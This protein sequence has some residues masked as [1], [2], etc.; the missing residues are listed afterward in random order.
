M[1]KILKMKSTPNSQVRGAR[2]FRGFQ[3]LKS[4]FLA[5]AKWANKPPPANVRRSRKPA[6]DNPQASARRTIPWGNSAANSRY[7]RSERFRSRGNGIGHN[8]RGRGKACRGAR[9]RRQLRWRSNCFSKMN[10]CVLCSRNFVF[11]RCEIF[12]SDRFRKQMQGLTPLLREATSS[13]LT[14]RKSGRF[15]YF[16]QQKLAVPMPY[17]SSTFM[18]IALPSAVFAYTK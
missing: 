9:Y 2:I 17:C 3:G 12:L 14:R 6:A 15:S 8:R 18:N 11:A 16:P 7:A 4:R 1:K 10:H 5:A 13:K